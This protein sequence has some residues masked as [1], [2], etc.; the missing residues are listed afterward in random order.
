MGIGSP[1]RRLR[2]VPGR[3]DQSRSSGAVGR[4]R[5][6][7]N[8]ANLQLISRVVD[9]PLGERDV[10]RAFR[11]DSLSTALGGIFNTYPYASFSQNIGI[12]SLT[13]VK[14]RFVVAAAGPI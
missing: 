10:A 11:A 13:G 8:L 6:I 12:I 2:S 1:L 7:E 9:R 14:S 4:H 3:T 5:V